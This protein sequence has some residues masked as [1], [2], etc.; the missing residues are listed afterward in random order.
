M[1]L[2]LIPPSVTRIVTSAMPREKSRSASVL[3]GIACRHFSRLA[4]AKP[5]CDLPVSIYRV[6][7][8]NCAKF[9]LQ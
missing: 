9:F 8:K 1:S 2:Q 4:D 3:R 6:G 7:Q 5:G